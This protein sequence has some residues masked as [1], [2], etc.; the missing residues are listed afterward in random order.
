MNLKIQTDDGALGHRRR[1][2]AVFLAAEYSRIEQ[3][4]RLVLFP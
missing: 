3:M 1:R 2:E 4:R